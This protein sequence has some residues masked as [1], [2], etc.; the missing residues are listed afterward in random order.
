MLSNFDN[1]GEALQAPPLTPFSCLKCLNP[2]VIQPLQPKSFYAYNAEKRR[3]V[4]SLFNTQNY[5]LMV[6]MKENC[7]SIS[8]IFET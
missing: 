7:L 2:P 4:I 8:K 3:F 1:L 6:M 5:V